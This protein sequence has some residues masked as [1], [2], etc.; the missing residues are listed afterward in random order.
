MYDSPLELRFD[1]KTIKHLGVRMYSTLPPAL[2]EIVANA[3]DADASN[4][5]I[6]LIE[7][8]GVP[9]EISVE[10]DGIG[11]SLAEINSKFLVIG[12]NRRAVEG[13]VPS[14]KHGRL[15]TGKK[16]LGKLA[17]FG[18]AET[19]TIE[20]RQS[21]KLNEFVLDWDELLDSEG[22]YRP[23]INKIDDI[24]EYSDGTV[25]KLTDLK[26]KS[27]FDGAALADSLSRLFIFDESF[28]LVLESPSGEKIVIDNTRK[29]L[30]V[31]VEF[32]W[33]VK[34][35]DLIRAEYEHADDLTGM[36]ITSKRPLTPA[37]GLRGVTLF[38]R[39]KLVN[40]P[41]FFSNSTSSHF[42]QY[43]TGWISVDHIDKLE[44]DVISTNRQSLDW[45][46]PEMS[47]LRDIL[48]RVVSNVNTDWRKR[49]KTKKEEE[50]VEITG[51]DTEQWMA[52]MPGDVRA[53]TQQ[54]IESLGGEDAFEKYT[55][56]IQALHALI[57]A[58]P[59]LHWRHLHAELQER[60]RPYYE[61][62]QYG[63]A[64]NQSVL[65]YCEVIRQLTGRV[66]DGNDLVNRV[67][68]KKPFLETRSIPEVQLNTLST[69]SDRD[70]Q[71]GQS[72][73]SRGVVTGFRNPITHAPIDSSVPSVFSEL[74]CLNI[75]SLVSYLLTRL[76][77]SHV[78][79]T[80]TDGPSS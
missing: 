26:R 66:E 23:R 34:S 39:G 5:V 70:I 67:F 45:Q 43:L 18:L 7:R 49:R 42:Y 63:D 22:N 4:V 29:Y 32:E 74:D 58:Y 24:T 77:G 14:R 20:T 75:L 44:D 65:I 71:E 9:H 79:Q 54:I 11:L 50:L 68:G 64:A 27:P 48:S 41:E 51:I 72:H 52:T 59:L 57:P 36:L 73:L 19:I 78:N 62:R 15:P 12:R 2:A 6:R 16:G 31:D 46:R 13:D 76:D 8:N 28:N 61:N 10:D 25:I 40:A 21:G 69:E 80:V 47:K 37:S 38:S 35:P 3:Y 55:P 17:L 1:P 53:S 30:A 60:V 33:V 56:V